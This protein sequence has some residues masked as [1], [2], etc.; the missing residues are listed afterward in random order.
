MARG[1]GRGGADALLAFPRRDN[2]VAY[3]EELGRELPVI[4]FYLYEAAGGVAYDTDT[5]HAILALPAVI[6]IKVATLDSVMTFQRITAVI[7]DHP[8]KVLITG[9]DRF[10]GYSLMMGARAALIGMGAAL[11]DVQAALLSADAS[12]DDR[13]FV[14][15]ATQ[16]DAFSPVTITAPME[17][18]I[19][20]IV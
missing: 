8:D 12:G 9:E 2:P 19:R 11:T 6:G 3:H 18:Y 20:C 15:V 14:R 7:G 10:L 17:G 1:A 5:L 16:L 13:A 4:A